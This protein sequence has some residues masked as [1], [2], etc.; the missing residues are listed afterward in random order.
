MAAPVEPK[1]AGGA[2]L[3]QIAIATGGAAVLT[4]A[5]LLGG[6][7][8]RTGRT[9]VL[10]TAA[11]FFERAKPTRGLP[12]WVGLPTYAAMVSLITALLGMYW[13]ISLHISQGRDEGPLANIAHYPILIGLFGIFASGVLAMVLPLGREKPGPA[14]VRITKD[15]YAPVGGVLLAGA[16]F[17]AL[18]GFPLDDAWHRVFGQDVTLWGPTHLMLIGGA[19]L[20]LVALAVLDREG[21][22]A[23]QGS[24]G[25]TSGRQFLYR[26]MMMGGFLI[27]LSVF[28]AE[29]DFGVPQFRMVH[30]PYLIAAAAACALVVA[31]LWVGRYGALFAVGFYLLVRG[32]VAV[33]VGPA[34]GELFATV[35]FYLGEAVIIELLAVVLARHVLAFGVVAGVLV[36]TVG[37]AVQ[38]AWSQVAFPLPWTPDMLG[39]GLLSA[40]LGG[41]GGGLAG[42]LM[43]LGLWGRLPRPAVSRSLLATSLVLV[44]VA[45]GNAL[46]HTVPQGANAAVTLGPVRDGMAESLTVRMDPPSTVDD[47][48][49]FTVTAW[50]GGDL[51]VDRLVPA[52]DGS[53]RTTEP[54]PV[55]GDWKTLLRVHEGRSMGGVEIYLPADPALNA[56][57]VPADPSFIRPVIPEHEI[58]QRELEPGV[59]VWLFTVGSVV[60]LGLTLAL[61]LSLAWGVGRTARCGPDRVR[62]VEAGD[63]DRQVAQA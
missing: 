31:R 22:L 30:Q 60:V 7:A 41:V 52:G 29:W 18:L 2:A 50:Q 39:E 27:G 4:A 13:D 48:T 45:V 10:A 44:A 59:P 47:P 35:P 19:G 40:L 11:A 12:G 34:L 51:H 56:S 37:Y 58:L 63:A 21:R 43:V 20:S 32:G 23:R 5:L 61:V 33:V 9:Q 25:Q 42:A 54:V 14:A 1:A 8:H 16:G 17:Y 3:D 26:G 6:W 57:L 36:G 55:S 15:W 24:T 38:Y 53:W 49:W 46:V 28:Q 62:G